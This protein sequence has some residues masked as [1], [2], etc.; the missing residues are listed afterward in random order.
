MQAN[1][2]QSRFYHSLVA[3]LVRRNNT[4]YPV[5]STHSI[6]PEDETDSISLQNDEIHHLRMSLQTTQED[7]DMLQKA[8]GRNRTMVL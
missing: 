4:S 2:E 8:N 5:P 1:E 6:I 7:V 3:A